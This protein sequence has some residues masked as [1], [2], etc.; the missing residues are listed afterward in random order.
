MV[1][2]LIT[3]VSSVGDNSMMIESSSVGTKRKVCGGGSSLQKKG[4]WKCVSTT[5]VKKGFHVSPQQC[6]DK[7]NDLNK[8]YKRLI[9]ILGRG[10]CCQVVSNH[11]L[12]DSMDHVSPKS[13][14]AVRK[15]LNSKHLFYKEMCTYHN[16]QITSVATDP[17][18]VSPWLPE[19]EQECLRKRRLKLHEEKV[20]IDAELL[21]MEKQRLNWMRL[22]EEKDVEVEKARVDNQRMASSENQRLTMQLKLKAK[23]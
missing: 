18:A 3:V 9:D 14:S 17:L 16:G 13:K 23:R 22:C 10:K 8:R 21:M 4:K 2:L 7:F 5:M 19:E 1:Q 15:I 12:L 11:S 6:E 20:E